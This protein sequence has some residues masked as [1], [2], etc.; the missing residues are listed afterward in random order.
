MGADRG[1]LT[2]ADGV[3]E[4]IAATALGEVEHLGGPAR[5]MLGVAVGSTNPDRL[6]HVEAVVTGTIVSLQVRA[7]VTYPAP[8]G[9]VADRARRHVT[10]RLDALTGLSVRQV[11]IT[12]TALPA[13]VVKGRTLR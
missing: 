9:A 11:D 3:V 7:T 10:D 2:I 5:Q 1:S 8:V 13:P 12:V 6:P 4:R